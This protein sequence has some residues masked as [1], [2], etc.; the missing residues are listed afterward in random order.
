MNPLQLLLC[1]L[2]CILPDALEPLNLLYLSL[3]LLLI[4]YNR[5]RHLV[6]A[7]RWGQGRSKAHFHSIGSAHGCLNLRKTSLAYNFPSWVATGIVILLRIDIIIVMSVWYV[8]IKV[9]FVAVL[10]VRGWYK[11]CFVGDMWQVLGVTEVV[12]SATAYQASG[13]VLVWLLLFELEG[14]P[15]RAIDDIRA[16]FDFSR[17]SLIRFAVMML[18]HNAQS[19]TDCLKMLYI[20]KNQKNNKSLYFSFCSD[21]DYIAFQ[22]SL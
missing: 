16:S 11:T 15:P 4:L 7:L 8:D 2:H 10:E 19:Q 3:H 18:M 5:L 9:K 6:K 13:Y 21:N 20:K 14:T 1:L 12:A 17:T 22:R